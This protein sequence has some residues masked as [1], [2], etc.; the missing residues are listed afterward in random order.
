MYLLL[1]EVV[2]AAAVVVGLTVTALLVDLPGRQQ[3]TEAVVILAVLAAAAGALLA[4]V[5]EVLRLERAAKQLHSMETPLH[6]MALERH[7]ELSHKEKP[8]HSN[9]H[10]FIQLADNICT[11][12][13]RRFYWMSLP[14]TPQKH[15]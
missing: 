4:V 13:A 5:R 11:Q 3:L 10:I 7:M 8:C 2:L 12:I 9:T 1:L 6:R 15:M 14:S